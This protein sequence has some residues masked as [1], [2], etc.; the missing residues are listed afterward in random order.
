MMMMNHARPGHPE[1]A[2][3]FP[4][5]PMRPTAPP[6]HQVV[7][8]DAV[9]EDIRQLLTTSQPFWPADASPDGPNY[10]PF[11]IRLAWHCTGSYRNSD[12]RGGCDGGNMRFEPV[13][14]WPDN[15][16]L[17]K[18]LRLLEPIKTKYGAA[19]SWG[20]LIVLTGN[21]AIESMGGPV[22]GFC[23]GRIDEVD[24]SE[25][26]E[27]GPTAIQQE[28]APCDVNGQ[29]QPPLGTDT[30]GLIYV[31]PEGVMARHIPSESAPEIRQVFARMDMNDSETVSLIG[32]GHAFGR[33]H[34]ACPAGAG[35]SPKED[36]Y[37][38]WPGLC[39]NG[40][41]TSGLNGPW[42]ATPTWWGNDYFRNLLSYKYE[43]VSTPGG[44][45]QFEPVSGQ[46]A[47]SIMMLTTDMALL[48]DVS[49]K[50]LV[51][52][53]ASSLSRL[54]N[55]FMHSWY[56]LTTRDMG[57]VTRCVG[58]DVPPAQPFQYPLPVTTPSD[59]DI[60]TARTLIQNS[61]YNGGAFSDPVNGRSYEGALYIQLAW[62][63]ASTFRHTDYRGGADGATIRFP[64][65]SQWTVNKGMDQVLQQLAPIKAQLG[66]A[67]SW[68]DLI[69]LAGNV[70][71][72]NASNNYSVYFCPG[73]GDATDGT[74]A[75]GLQPRSYITD[76]IRSA[77]D[78]M[79]VMGFTPEEFV[80]LAGRPRSPAY[81][82]GLGYSGS[83]MVNVDH[84]GND[85]F[86][87][88]LNHTWV[89]SNGQNATRPTTTQEYKAADADLY[90]TGADLAI[91]ASP[92]YRSIAENFAH[93]NDLFLHHFAFAWAKL[94]NADRFNGPW[95]NLCYPSRSD[96]CVCV[97]CQ[98]LFFE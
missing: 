82:K 63:S 88:L 31:N 81:M 91:L 38:P 45:K 44:A 26:W 28:I 71:I 75:S 27:L 98:S 62:Q 18:A 23:G 19:L 13:R 8:Y 94:M 9:K 3:H 11:F 53:F 92:M 25:S 72:E 68:A 49:Y 58:D 10:G 24:G 69:V 7:D 74:R 1:M 89:V 79:R 33:T 70:A 50:A 30:V 41:F 87:T 84:F 85:Y 66:D 93:S 48:E 56:K 77:V 78:N 12:G 21:T 97:I 83:W 37:N 46:G 35:P 4:H 55:A 64:P 29:C 34:G 40:T 60:N 65:Q 73:R 14:S 61:L 43:L 20:D 54:D 42:T 67:V 80:A 6:Q 17:D 90:I 2:P 95:G 15:T 96:V 57:P 86:V 76:P 39:P 32:G 51:K 22:L 5:R 36:P 52:E 16:N 47:P 59:D